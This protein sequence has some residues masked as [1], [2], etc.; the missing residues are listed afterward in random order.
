M[1]VLSLLAVLWMIVDRLER[2]PTKVMLLEHVLCFFPFAIHPGWIT[3]ATALN[4]SVVLVSA[5]CEHAIQRCAAIVAL[6]LLGLIA[7]TW[8]L[9]D[10][11]EHA[12]PVVRTLS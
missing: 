6:L 8:L 1:P 5:G 3:V 4:V 12:I 9:P 2:I 10:A 7:M 11:P